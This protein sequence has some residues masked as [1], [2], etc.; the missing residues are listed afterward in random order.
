M[1]VNRQSGV[2]VIKVHGHLWG[3][4]TEGTDSVAGKFCSK[5]LEASTNEFVGSNKN[6]QNPASSTVPGNQPSHQE[7]TERY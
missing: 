5:F 1:T 3:S 4:L 7:S 6:H 2:S